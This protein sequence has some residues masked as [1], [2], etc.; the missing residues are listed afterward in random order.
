MHSIIGVFS[1][2]VIFAIMVGI[3]IYLIK[4]NIFSNKIID[5]TKEAESLN[6][7]HRERLNNLK[8]ENDKLFREIT[9]LED[10]NRQ[11]RLK[12][13]QL[14]KIIRHLE[15]QKFQL[16]D[17]EER[18]K[19]LRAKKE[20]ALSIVAHDIKNPASTIKNFVELLESYDLTAQEQNDIL[21]GLVEI[22]TRIIK[23]A[24]EFSAVIKEEYRPFK[25]NKEKKNFYKTIEEVVKVNKIKAS[26]KG[27]D[28]RLYQPQNEIFINIDEEK[29]KEVI[30]NY[31]CNAIKYCPEKSK[32]EIIT[33]SDKNYISVEVKDNGHGLTEEE[34]NHAFE[35]G[36]ILSTKPTGGE[37]SSG[38]G[39]WIVKKIVEEHNGK[40]WVKSKKG[41]GSTFAFTLP[42]K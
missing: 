33:N 17:N 14:K 2:V 37:S 22:S 4:K 18:L 7:S 40:V 36:S 32:V 26:K 12:I 1:I 23:L 30:D 15:E 3:I 28:I 19:N 20:E 5:A 27:I 8:E 10:K 11:L 41:S 21:S 24:D 34:L 16:Q 29:I 35:K 31:V 42:I 38:L 6:S 9:F 39:L 13:D 25:I